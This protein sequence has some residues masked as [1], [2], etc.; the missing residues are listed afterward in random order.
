MRV[1][2]DKTGLASTLLCDYLHE[3]LAEKELTVRGC[4]CVC[5]CV[6]T[7]MHT[8]MPRAVTYPS[9]SI[10]TA[11]E[12]A[13]SLSPLI[14][15]LYFIDPKTYFFFSHFSISNCC[16]SYICWCVII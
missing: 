4:V 14:L 13:E 12:L 5:T 15:T 16:V 7:C 10:H 9:L 8:C 2:V 3:L 1:L 11:K 6:H